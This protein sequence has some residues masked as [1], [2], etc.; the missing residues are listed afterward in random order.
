[1]SELMRNWN[2]KAPLTL[3]GTGCIVVDDFINLRG[4]VTMNGNLI[5]DIR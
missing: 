1:M 3:K 2:D 4:T 5:V